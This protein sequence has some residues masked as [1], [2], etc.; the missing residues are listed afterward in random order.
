MAEANAL[1]W[2]VFDDNADVTK[3]KTRRGRVV[4]LLFPDVIEH[5]RK[6]KELGGKYV[7]GA[8]TDGNKPWDRDDC[9]KRCAE[10]YPRI[11][12]GIDCDDVFEYGRTHVWRESLNSLMLDVPVEV[13][14]AYFGHDPE[15]NRGYYTDVTD[16]TPMIDA[17]RK[18]R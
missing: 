3:S 7:I 16:V 10:F 17:A 15:V 5:L 13:R 12:K 18:I 14:A 4:P 1:T 2:E 11:G 8:P 9:R 6:R